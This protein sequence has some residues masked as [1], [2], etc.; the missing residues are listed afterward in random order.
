[1][2]EHEESL[3]SG[4]GDERSVT[5]SPPY[6]VTV[7]PCPRVTPSPFR[8]WLYL[9][10]LCIQRQ[11]RMRQMVWIALGLLMLAATMVGLQTL[12]GRWGMNHWRSWW[13]EPRPGML[14]GADIR[15][16]KSADAK[17]QPGFKP[18]NVVVSTFDQTATGLDIL[19]AGLPALSTA[20][21]GKSPI[22]PGQV[23]FIEEQMAVQRAI[24]GAVRLSLKQS[25]FYVF[26]NFMIFSIFIGFL[27]PIWTLSF[28]TE[29]IGGEREGRSLVWLL[30]RPLS[31]PSIY[32]AKFIAILPWCLLLNFGGFCL[33]CLL[34]G[35]PGQLAMRLYW[36]AVL[37]GTVAF[38]ALFH[39]MAACFRRAAVVGLV[40]S[41]FLEIFLGT[42]PGYMKRISLSFYTR[43]LMFEAADEYSVRPEKPSIYLP[44]DSATAWCVLLGVTLILLIVG[45]I[46]FARTEY[47]DLS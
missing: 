46:I 35:K 19:S 30:S 5:L 14:P 23:I 12:G 47:Q 22:D 42:M 38:S 9:I 31:R 40:Y 1:M 20:V 7:S 8:A 2:S 18:P 11:A 21:E 32:L 4:V 3:G 45:T 13:V 41:F 17:N 36:P 29:A 16:L 43:C 15:Q 37:G 27:L 24:A 39:L 44:V 10:W 6:P 33:I 28:A 25:P 26:S 34:A